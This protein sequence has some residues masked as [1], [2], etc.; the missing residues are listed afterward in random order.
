MKL[1]DK[2]FTEKIVVSCQKCGKKCEWND[3]E[4]DHILPWNRG[5]QTV[6]ENGQVLCTSCNSRK[7][8][9]LE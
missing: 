2:L 8:D 3:Y 5:G 9:S 1:R 4:A 6:V 7:G